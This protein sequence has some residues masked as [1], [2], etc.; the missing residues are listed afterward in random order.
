MIGYFLP[1]TALALDYVPLAPLPVG[2]GGASLTRVTDAGQ[3]IKGAFNLAIGIAA[4]LAIIMIVIGGIQYMGTESIGG[5]GAGLKKIKDA[6]LGLLLALGSYILLF[7]IN[8]ALTN[9]SLTIARIEPPPQTTPVTQPPTVS[10]EAR[11][12]DLAARHDAAL[13]Q[14]R[15]DAVGNAAMLDEVAAEY[16]AE[17]LALAA[18][19]DC[20]GPESVAKQDC[21]AL[22]AYYATE[23]GK[24]KVEATLIEFAGKTRENYQTILNSFATLPADP[25]K[26]E[27]GTKVQV[28]N[29]LKNTMDG[30]YQDELTEL[31]NRNAD[32]YTIDKLLTEWATRDT[33]I[34]RN[35]AETHMLGTDRTYLS[36]ERNAAIIEIMDNKIVPDTKAK[37]AELN[38][39]QEAKNEI[40]RIANLALFSLQASCRTRL[41]VVCANYQPN[42]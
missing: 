1:F 8:P 40:Q 6:V 2:E 37:I 14:R 20:T 29:E 4:V 18:S 12:A 42:W 10:E 11:I 33:A 32:Q 3:Y 39:S 25:T 38:T 7:T 35:I 41:L 27:I 26:T 23:A 13:M 21:L 36:S 15:A 19:A 28:V 17:A 31:R 16:E 5:K 34:S 30:N 24:I 9:F 22:S